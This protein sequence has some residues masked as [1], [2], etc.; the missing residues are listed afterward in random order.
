MPQCPKPSCHQAMHELWLPQ[1]GE[2]TA[3]KMYK[4]GFAHTNNIINGGL[5]CRNTSTAAFTQKVVLRSEL[6]KYYLSVLGFSN[7]EIAQED[8]GN[9]STLCYE[10]SSNAMQDYVNCAQ[11]V[12]NSQNFDINLLEIYPNPG[13]D[14]V[15]I[16]YNQLIDTIEIY[17][18]LGQIIHTLNNQTNLSLILNTTKLPTGM[19]SF[20]IKSNSSSVATVHW[21]K[22]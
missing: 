2:Y 17:N 20:K 9:Y 8:S 19:Y 16:S 21:I 14:E 11:T 13:T 15:V 7:T 5:E 6:Y 4:K 18:S 22:K 10:N 12:L 3:T 1:T